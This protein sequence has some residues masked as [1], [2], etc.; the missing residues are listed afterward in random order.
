MFKTAA[1]RYSVFAATLGISVAALMFALEPK[2]IV[3]SIIGMAVLSLI[4]YV[5]YRIVSKKSE[6]EQKHIAVRNG[7]VAW[8]MVVVLLAVFFIAAAK[9]NDVSVIHFIR[10]WFG[11]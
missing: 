4:I 10:V 3:P 2:M 7:K 5:F 1:V 9:H 11:F 8:V 6:A